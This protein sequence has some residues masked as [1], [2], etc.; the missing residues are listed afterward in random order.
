MKTK[1]LLVS[2]VMLA[3]CARTIPA[4]TP[5]EEAVKVKW[6]EF[7]ANCISSGQTYENCVQICSDEVFSQVGDPGVAENIACRA[8]ARKATQ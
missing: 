1:I 4:P 5:A 7:G 2:F 3:A 6:R 8:G